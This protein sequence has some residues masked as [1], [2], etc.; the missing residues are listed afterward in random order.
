M[1]NTPEFK[2]QGTIRSS[3][4]K[5]FEPQLSQSDIEA[6]SNV[7][8]LKGTISELFSIKV[9]RN[10]L[11]IMM[12]TWSFASFAFFLVPLYIGNADLNLYLISIC[13]ALAEIISSLICLFIT[14]NRDNKKSL[15]V[16]CLL[17]CIGSVGA[18]IF[19]SV[20]S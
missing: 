19:T 14:H 6:A 8:K 12:I 20:Y 2:P 13:L 15:I 18:L 5:K 17:S 3:S 1:D 11:I 4:V 10:N 16:F 7:M 9:Y